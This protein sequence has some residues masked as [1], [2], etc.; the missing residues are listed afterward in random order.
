MFDRWNV[1]AGGVIAF[2]SQN[3]RMGSDKTALRVSLPPLGVRSGAETTFYVLMPSPW[4]PPS[5]CSRPLSVMRH[6]PMDIWSYC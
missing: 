3:A 4:T 1:P 6:C 5:M 2:T